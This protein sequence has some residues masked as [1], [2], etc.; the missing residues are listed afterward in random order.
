M[1]ALPKFANWS[2]KAKF[3]LCSGA[4]MFAF[5]VAFT[6]WTLR[7]VQTDLRSS[8]VDAQQ[9]LL[10]ATA[11]DVEAK[12]ELRRDALA[13]ISVLLSEAAPAPGPQMDTFFAPRPVLRKMFDAVLVVDK[14]GSVVYDSQHRAAPATD[15]VS[16]RAYFKALMAGSGQLISAPMRPLAGGEP[17]I[18][19][20]APLH[21]RDGT[22]SG[23]LVCTLNLQRGNFLGELSQVRI[24]RQG[25][26]TIVE[27]NDS[28]LFVMHKDPQ[29]VMTLAAEGANNPV[30]VLASKG[31]DGTLEGPN[32]MGIDTL[33]S[34][35]PLRSVPWILVTVYPTEEAFAQ[36]HNR[37]REVIWTGLGLFL[38]AS[39]GAWLM[40]ARLLQPLA[41]LRVEMD[42]HASEPGL[43]IAPETFGSTELAALV[44][45]YNAQALRRSEFERRLK[46]KERF[47]KDITDNL[48]A[49]IGYIDK[50]LR[51]TFL[52]TA[53]RTWLGVDPALSVGRHFADVFGPETYASRVEMF[54]RCL[55]GERVVFEVDAQTLVGKKTLQVVYIPDC[56]PDGNVAGFY[57]LSSDVTELTQA[58]RQL[59][60][61]VRSDSLTGL[62]NRY[63]F[64]EALPLAL[65]R[66]KRSGLAMALMFLDVDHFKQVNDTLGHA[67][68][69]T[70]LREFA[71]RL[72]QS[73]RSTDTVAR[74]GGD[75]FVVI[76]EGLHSD[77]EPRFVA[78]KIL[79]G[80]DRPFDIDGGLS[81]VTT[82]VGVAFHTAASEGPADLLARADAAL[83]QAKAA[84]RNTYRLAAA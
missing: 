50:E 31:L 8:I 24:G 78:R 68:G 66:S 62:P 38:A 14:A 61:L 64:N 77:E 43:P 76:L 58:Q 22:F 19:F 25:Y 5:S 65:A 32:S 44:L 10:R 82:S 13:T 75:E 53:F 18:V 71:R 3:A 42:R 48:P 45:A 74:L 33:R 7:G 20:A 47:M 30:Q 15:E 1:I 9:A 81:R 67:A 63:Q 72:Q 23:A 6:T 29:R 39:A 16:G 51:Y 4:L 49:M 60:Q 70:L 57:T 36:L 80:I 2:L 46:D 83:Y 26:F 37:Q 27:R 12:V 73:V 84:G 17:F 40:S 34:F 28:P 21:A 55:T 59:G 11:R 56:A 54:R 69:D 41:R 35:T 52:N 79:A